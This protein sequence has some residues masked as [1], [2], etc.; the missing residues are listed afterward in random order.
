MNRRGSER[1]QALVL[2]VVFLT[3]LLGMTAL[4]VDVGTWFYAKR[5]L[6]AVA[7]AAALAGA[8]ALP[9]NVN[10]AESLAIQYAAANN[11]TLTASGISF[12]SDLAPND[13][14]SVKLSEPEPSFFAKVLGISSVT[15]GASA[16]AR[17]DNVSAARYVAPIT[18][19]W[20][21]PDLQCSPLPC[22]SPTT[23]DLADLHKPGSGDAA[24][25]FGLIDLN[26]KDNGSAGSGTLASWITS[27]YDAYMPLGSYYAVPSTKW[28]SSSI[29]GAMSGSVGKVLLFPIYNSLANPGSNAVYNIIGWVG[30]HVTG[31]SSTGS[32]G[33][34]SGWFTRRISEGIQ[35]TSGSQVPDYGVRTV[36]LVN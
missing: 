28:N 17:S 16:S 32:G 4:A 34:V 2:T 35:V 10:Q 3:V 30:F 24:G 5:K 19:N 18:V 6:Q 36:Q 26:P 13:T 20:Q 15:V 9:D 31:F 14:I 7:D 33:T 22:S 12:S 8:Q 27:G 23:I 11:G 21:H 25:S 1:G 29:T